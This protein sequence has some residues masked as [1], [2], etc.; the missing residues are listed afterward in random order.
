MNKIRVPESV[1]LDN[2]NP[3]VAASANLLNTLVYL[4]EDNSLPERFLN[5]VAGDA[6]GHNKGKCNG[7]PVDC[8]C[9]P[10]D[11]GSAA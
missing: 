6:N 9:P 10:L 4:P 3:T 5:L 8:L 1:P 11:Y 2:G 7:D